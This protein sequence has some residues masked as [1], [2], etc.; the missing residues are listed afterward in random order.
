MSNTFSTRIKELRTALKMTQS[1]IATS[2]GSSQNALSGYENGD[3]IPSYEILLSIA[4]TYN[5]SIVDRDKE[6][7][8]RKD[9]NFNFVSLNSFGL[10]NSW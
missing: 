8:S 4:K 10:C 5:V 2:I 3:R 6:Y 1:D 7:I 9:I